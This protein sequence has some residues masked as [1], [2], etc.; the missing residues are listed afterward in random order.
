MKEEISKLKPKIYKEVEEVEKR[1][2]NRKLSTEHIDKVLEAVSDTPAG[3][4]YVCGGAVP[5]SYT[6]RAEATRLEA[7]W[8][9]WRKEKY[10]AYSVWRGSAKKVPWG[11]GP[12]YKI[13]TDAMGR[14]KAYAELFPLRY[15]KLRKV[16]EQRLLLRLA[17]ELSVVTPPLETVE[18]VVAH[19]IKLR[20]IVVETINM[21]YLCTPLGYISLKSISPHHRRKTSI[22]KIC[23]ELFQIK[24]ATSW[25]KIEPYVYMY[26]IST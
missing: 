5:S 20:C 2:R 21:D 10:I 4:A 12:W 26:L 11:S 22:S 15:R 19:S 9:T 23:Q 1:A 13:M 24:K 7:Y 17:T 3:F 8:Y 25:E 18:K 14:S 6:Y 16:K